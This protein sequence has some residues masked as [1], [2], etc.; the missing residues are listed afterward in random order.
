MPQKKPDWFRPGDYG[1]DDDDWQAAWTASTL[2]DPWRDAKGNHTTER[3]VKLMLYDVREFGGVDPQ[4]VQPSHVVRLSQF[5]EWSWLGSCAYDPVARLFFVFELSP[6][7]D[8]REASR[9]EKPKVHVWRVEVPNGGASEPEPEPEP[10]PDYEGLPRSGWL[11]VTATDEEGITYHGEIR[12]E[13][14]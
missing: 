4:E 12:R 8:S 14:G 9:G 5:H 10:E 3:A 6:A 2:R 1:F 13:N 11:R 7:T